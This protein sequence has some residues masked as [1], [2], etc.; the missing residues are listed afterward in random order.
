MPAA[1]ALVVLVLH[2][3]AIWAALRTGGSLVPAVWLCRAACAGAAAYAA[4]TIRRG[5][6]VAVDQAALAA[7]AIEAVLLV[8]MFVPRPD[9]V[10][11]CV[12]I[13]HTLAAAAVAWFLTCFRMTRL[14]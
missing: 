9:W 6:S 3:A 12:L 14:W 11:W 1:I 4:W 10:V 2:A 8:L 7:L 5:M 13:A